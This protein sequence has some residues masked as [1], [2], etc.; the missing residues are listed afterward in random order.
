MDKASAS[1]VM[2][3]AVA[4]DK[5][6][7]DLL[8]AIEAVPDEGERKRLLKAVTD[9]MRILTAEVFF[10]IERQYPDLNPDKGLPRGLW[11]RDD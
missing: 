5:P 6:I 3:R 4:L 1:L 7:G 8:S 2:D 11:K 10:A 9:V